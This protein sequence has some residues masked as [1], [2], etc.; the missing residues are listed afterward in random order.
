VRRVN[1][2][3]ELPGALDLIRAA[4]TAGIAVA[5]GHS[6]ATY[7]QA[8]AA[9]DA[10][11]TSVTHTF[12]AMSGL[13]HRAPGLAAAALTDDRLLCELILDGVH[14]HP[15]AARALWRARGCDGIALITDAAPVAGLADGDYRFLGQ[16]VRV[17]GG[18]CRLADGTLA[19][20]VAT[21]D[22]VARRGHELAGG[23][24]VAL[25]ALTSGNAARAMA[26]AG[27]T[28]TIQVGLDADLV[29]L[30]EQRAVLATMVRGQLVYVSDTIM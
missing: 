30:D 28:G 24:L 23:D 1:V 29:L 17:R 15:A 10:G 27:H 7:E 18:A 6:A 19:G 9:A 4:R 8:V 3:P 16:P 11:A 26:C 21:F 25:A 22:A 12:N 2:A 5:L 13:D 20:S 14:V